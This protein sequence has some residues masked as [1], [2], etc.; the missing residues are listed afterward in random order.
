MD[1][2]EVLSLTCPILDGVERG[3][4]SSRAFILGLLQFLAPLRGGLGQREAFAGRDSHLEPVVAPTSPSNPHVPRT[5]IT[6]VARVYDWSV[7]VLDVGRI[8]KWPR[9]HERALLVHV[10]FGD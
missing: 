2:H 1:I 9:Q 10:S 6:R 3:L 4:L 8:G 7:R 5:G